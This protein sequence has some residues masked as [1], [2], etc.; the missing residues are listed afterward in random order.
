[1]KQLTFDEVFKIWMD[2]EV[3]QVEGRDTLPVAK[4]KGFNSITEWRLATALRFGMDKKDWTLETI[5]NPGKELPKII[6]GPYPGWSKFFDNQLTTTFA[7]AMEIPEFFKWCKTH[8]RVVPLSEN[9]PLP[10]T[11]ILFRK[12]NGDLLHI[13]GGHRICAVA[14]ANILGKPIQFDDQR[15]VTAAIADVSEAEVVNLIELIKRGTGK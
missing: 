1:M 2:A 4:A 15:P 8:D 6:I 3:M 12:P 14:Y 5:K 13:E 7:Q 11:I 10:T 9:F